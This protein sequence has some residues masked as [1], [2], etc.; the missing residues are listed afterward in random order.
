MHTSP[1]N[2]LFL[3]CSA[4]IPKAGFKVKKLTQKVLKNLCQKFKSHV[5]RSSYDM[6][7]KYG[8]IAVIGFSNRKSIQ[9]DLHKRAQTVK[10]KSK[11]RSPNEQ[12]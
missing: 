12:L 1:K 9:T 4:K 10:S 7:S 11:V 6:H 5:V 2:T 8:L 3:W